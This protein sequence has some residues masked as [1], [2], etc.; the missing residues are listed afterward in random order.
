MTLLL[1]IGTHAD[2]QS[3]ALPPTICF[4]PWPLSDIMM[5]QKMCTSCLHDTHVM[6]LLDKN[7]LYRYPSGAIS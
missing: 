7:I 4:I 5:D 3:A 2:E 6:V 1:Q